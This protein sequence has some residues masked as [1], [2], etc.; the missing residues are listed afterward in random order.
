MKTSWPAK[1]YH[2]QVCHLPR[3]CVL[4][5]ATSVPYAVRYARSSAGAVAT[6]ARV[7]RRSLMVAEF[8]AP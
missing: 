8:S 5:F 1:Q 4:A 3:H 7:T 2:H 6:E